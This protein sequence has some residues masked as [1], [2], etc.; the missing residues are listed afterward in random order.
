MRQPAPTGASYV[1]CMSAAAQGPVPPQYQ[2][3]PSMQPMQ[4]MQPAPP[5]RRIFAVLALVAAGLEL[6]SGPASAVFIALAIRS[7]DAPSAIG[8]GTGAISIASGILG[9]A[10]VALAIVSLVLR[11][12]ARLLAGIALGVALAALVG[13]V[14]SGLQYALLAF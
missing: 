2:P 9:V 12:P 6:L 4:S 11:E 13:L 1:E 14:A 8:I 3:H 10:A 5:R 7:G